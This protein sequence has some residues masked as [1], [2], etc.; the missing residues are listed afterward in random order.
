MMRCCRKNSVG[1]QVDLNASLLYKTKA[2]AAAATP[3]QVQQCLLKD[4]ASITILIP[5][6][7]FPQSSSFLAIPWTSAVK[8]DTSRVQST[9]SLHKLFL[10][11]V[12]TRPTFTSTNHLISVPSN[13]MKLLTRVRAQIS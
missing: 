13:Q 1:T 7:C 2:H 5:R 3:F 9:F 12:A 10:Q 6:N 11:Q 8:V 4:I